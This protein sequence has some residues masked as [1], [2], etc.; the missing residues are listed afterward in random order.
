MRRQAIITFL[1]LAL[2]LVLA[3]TSGAGTAAGRGAARRRAHTSSRAGLTIRWDIVGYDFQATPVT[4]SPG[5]RASAKA[6]DRSAITL[7]GSGTF[8]GGATKVTRGGNWTTLGPGGRMTGS[9]TY[10]VK[11]LIGFFAAPGTFG[12]ASGKYQLVDQIGDSAN[13]HAGLLILR[14]VYS[15]GS[16]GTLTISSRQAGTPLSVFMG[17]TATKGFVGYWLLQ[18]ARAGVDGNRA[19]FHVL[20]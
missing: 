7:T 4:V 19:L 16:Q 5:G 13:A 20:S 11:T 2:V 6:S 17:I 18:P 15:D 3:G 8:G 12:D 1:A 10:K 9:G 14:V